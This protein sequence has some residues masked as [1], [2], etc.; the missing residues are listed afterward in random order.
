MG[1]RNEWSLL[2]VRVFLG[3]AFF[4][5]GLDK[6][7]MGVGNF[8]AGMPAMGL[9]E[10]LGYVVATIELVGGLFLIFGLFTRVVAIL[11]GIIMI[12]AIFT[13]KLPG[14]FLNGFE[15][16]LAYLVMSIVLIISGS[17]LFSL[18]QLLFQNR[19]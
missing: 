2:I 16:D 18:D 17:R 3:I 1:T 11:T 15:L 4:I 14:P 7:L 6:Y 19:K 13:A 10:F 12:G 8:A 5:H 9:P